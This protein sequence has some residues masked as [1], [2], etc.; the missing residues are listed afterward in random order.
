ML[1]LKILILSFQSA[2]SSA[3]WLVLMTTFGGLVV[4]TLLIA[5]NASARNAAIALACA[6]VPLIIGAAGTQHAVAV[7]RE[8]IV[9]VP[10]AQ[11][12]AAMASGICFGLSTMVLGA[13]ASAFLGAVGVVTL[14]LASVIRR[15]FVVTPGKA[16]EQ[17]LARMTAL[18]LGIGAAGTSAV[19]GLA[20]WVYGRAAYYN[21]VANV[22]KAQR[23][24]AMAMG[25]TAARQWAVIG[26]VGLV[27]FTVAGLYVMSRFPAPEPPPAPD[28]GRS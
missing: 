11:R 18:L 27:V 1:F 8:A 21:A 25:E 5:L 9:H 10:E 4:V 17:I 28:A 15:T 20:G 6:L 22:P 23:E 19:A 3:A 26:L 13:T 12:D 16:K 14:A 7:A 2:G 24:A